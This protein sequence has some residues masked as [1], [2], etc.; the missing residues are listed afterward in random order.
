ML[1]GRGPSPS[2]EVLLPTWGSFG[3]ISDGEEK[4]EDEQEEGALAMATVATVQDLS[5]LTECRD[6]SQSMWLHYPHLELLVLFFAFEGTFSSLASAIKA[7]SNCDEF[8]YPA[9][10]TLVSSTRKLGNSGFM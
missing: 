10:L 1:T 5:P 8:L 7:A 3:D 4:S 9:I 6:K 2:G